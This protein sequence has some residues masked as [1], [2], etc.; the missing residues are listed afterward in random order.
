MTTTI[1]TSLEGLTL[2]V[3][4]VEHSRAF[5]ERI[6]G[7]V[8]AAHRP[9]EF[10]LF[11]IGG[12]LLGLL[13]LPK[14]GFHIE[15]GASDLDGIHERLVQAGIRPAGPPRDRPW[16]ERTFNLIDPDGNVLEFQDG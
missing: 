15:I 13:Q 10:A 5:Y 1:R 4:D 9:G 14:G 16:G 6:P 2:H 11:E 8:L 3:K 7:V 12:G